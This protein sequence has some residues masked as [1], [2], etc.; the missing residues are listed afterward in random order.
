M[1]NLVERS[2]SKGVKNKVYSIREQFFQS[3]H[4]LLNKAGN[5]SIGKANISLGRIYIS[6]CVE[7]RSDEG[8]G[9]KHGQ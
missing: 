5:F 2:H 8:A 6:A 7:V 4:R 9:I 1:F 3:R